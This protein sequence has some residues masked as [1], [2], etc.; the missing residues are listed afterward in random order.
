MNPTLGKAKIYLVDD[1]PIVRR[2]LHMLID[3]EPDMVV[4]GEAEDGR[5]ALGE[6]HKL[7]PDLVVVDLTLKNSSGLELVKQLRSLCPQVRL[8]VFT[9]HDEPLYGE[10]V[11][12]AGAQ[13]YLTKE[14]GPE[15]AIEAIRELLHGKPFIS[16]GLASRMV[17]TMT[18][19]A[20]PVNGPSV[21]S[22][23][24]RELEVV[25]LI[26]QG[27]GSREIA[28]RLRLSVKT[29]ESHRER[30][31]AKLALPNSRAL[32]QYAFSW[33]NRKMQM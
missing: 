8:L 30:I 20:K 26:G 1:H 31:K 2:G 13:G 3:L 23:S 24:D 11:L 19:T 15:K 28:T 17:E 18:A 12:R 7:S 5:V 21:D 32:A 10:R 6:I 25:E 27:L 9:M 14:E 22:L 33:V 16:G 29:I 4:C